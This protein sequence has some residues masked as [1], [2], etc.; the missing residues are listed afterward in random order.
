MAYASGTP[1]S[2]T[3]GELV[4]A[5]MMNQIRDAFNELSAG[6][7]TT[8]GDMLYATS[9]TVRAR[10]AK[11]TAYQQLVMNVGAS[12]PQ[13][14]TVP[15]C[16]VG[17]ASSLSINSGVTTYVGFDAEVIDTDSMHDN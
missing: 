5:A 11:G 6:V 8:A 12:A 3:T 7:L 9:G 16:R 10:L 2:W 4:T 15:V 13:W 1:R 17:R 14:F